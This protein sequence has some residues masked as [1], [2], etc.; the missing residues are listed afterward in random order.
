MTYT[1]TPTKKEKNNKENKYMVRFKYMCIF[2]YCRCVTDNIV[3]ISKALKNQFI[4]PEWLTFSTHI[5]EMFDEC[6]LNKE[7]KVGQ[8]FFRNFILNMIPVHE[9]V[10]LLGILT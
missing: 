6:T 10:K 4:I 3:L 9:S 1:G 7:G 2:R 8:F 5:K